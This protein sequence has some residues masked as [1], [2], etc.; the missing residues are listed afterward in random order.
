LESDLA[1]KVLRRRKPILGAVPFVAYVGIFLGIP[2]GSVVLNAFRSQSGSF[3][4]SNIH[5]ALSGGYR[6][7][8]I[9]S[10]KLSVIAT[11][12]AAIAGLLVAVAV[13]GMKDG[14]IKR[15]IMAASGVFANTGGVPLAFSFVATLGNFGL[16]TKI[17]LS[18][19]VNIYS[20]GFTL[21]SVTG[22]VIVYQ[23][24]MIPLMVLVMIPPLEGL[25]SQWFEAA[26]TLGASWPTMWRSIVAPV[27]MPPFIAASLLL[28]T[29]AFA[30]YATAAALTSGTIPLVPIQIGSLIQGNVVAN[31]GNL[32]A[33]LGLGMIV[34]VGIVAIAYVFVSRRSNRW[35]R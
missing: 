13:V 32:G 25:N 7:S 10:L 21:Y 12:I 24:F 28:F 18:G 20:G 29:D 35:L 16:I 2:A 1:I 17:L 3:T 5:S 22:L 26:Q 14:A 23:Y 9:Q 27:I 30:A 19:G 15:A 6:Q 8:F 31:Q 33:A 11:V 4:L 34:I